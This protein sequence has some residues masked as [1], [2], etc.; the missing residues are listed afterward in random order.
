VGTN[1]SKASLK[2][3]RPVVFT[4]WNLKPLRE[5]STSG[6]QE[7]LLHSFGEVLE[8]IAFPSRRSATESVEKGEGANMD[9]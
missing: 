3:K 5:S 7:L 6:K 1:N 2:V 8:E 9:K 4:K